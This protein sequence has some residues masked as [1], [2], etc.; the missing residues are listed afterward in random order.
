MTTVA[1]KNNCF[2]FRVWNPYLYTLGFGALLIY[3]NSLVWLVLSL[4]YSTLNVK[5]N[6]NSDIGDYSN[7]L[8]TKDCSMGLMYWLVFSQLSTG[9]LIMI[10][11]IMCFTNHYHENAYEDMI[12]KNLHNNMQFCKII[13]CLYLMLTLI[14]IPILF[15]YFHWYFAL[16]H[17]CLYASLYSY[18]ICLV[19]A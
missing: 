1:K 7:T 8:C 16:Y 4:E 19:L 17:A 15:V 13:S 9:A 6:S 3:A 18:I 2:C 12:V 14:N 11:V 10:T 5:N